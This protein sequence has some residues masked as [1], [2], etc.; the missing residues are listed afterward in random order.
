MIHFPA[1]PVLMQPKAG[2]IEGAVLTSEEIA[3]IESE[4][5]IMW[6]EEWIDGTFLAIYINDDGKLV[7]QKK[8]QVLSQKRKSSGLYFRVWDWIDAQ[9]EILLANLWPNK[10]LLGQWCAMKRTIHYDVLPDPYIITDVYDMDTGEFL[11]PEDRDRFADN[12]G[13]QTPPNGG[14]KLRCGFKD[15]I[16]DAKEESWFST[17]EGDEGKA[18]GL[19]VM[20]LIPDNNGKAVKV[21]RRFCIPNTSIPHIED[22]RYKI[23]NKIE[24]VPVEEMS[25]S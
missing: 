25:W 16:N 15:L 17:A 12:L 1:T 14:W 13:Y 7:V 11:V 4:L 19:S 6:T 22:S 18:K 20:E 2:I 8:N 21:G 10:V 3:E 23:T 24:G 5:R 9:E